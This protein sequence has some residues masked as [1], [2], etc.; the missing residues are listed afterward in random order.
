MPPSTEWRSL[1]SLAFQ[2]VRDR[3]FRVSQSIGQRSKESSERL[4]ATPT[5]EIRDRSHR[6]ID[7]LAS[8]LQQSRLLDRFT[9]EP[10]PLDLLDRDSHGSE[11]LVRCI[12]VF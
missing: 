1:D 12:S 4:I 3:G 7:Q 8:C 11:D 10:T 6:L 9:F 2:L 5:C